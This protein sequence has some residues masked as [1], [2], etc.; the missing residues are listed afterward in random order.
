MFIG[1]LR[2][3]RRSLHRCI[4][5]RPKYSSDTL[6]ISPGAYR[7]Q[8]ALT[9]RIQRLRSGRIAE[10]QH[11]HP[12]LV[13]VAAVRLAALLVWEVVQGSERA[14]RVVLQAGFLADCLLQSPW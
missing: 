8:T 3:R 10:T 13:L 7:A 2:L 1:L 6:G 5:I 12:A 11:R 4:S 14:A 9:H